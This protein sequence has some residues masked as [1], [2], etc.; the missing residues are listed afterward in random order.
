MGL[1]RVAVVAVILSSAACGGS[2]PGSVADVRPLSDG[3]LTAAHVAEAS[4]EAGLQL[5][6][7]IGLTNDGEGL[8]LS[9]S[10]IDV[11]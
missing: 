10:E 3:T 8:R 5:T 2:T 9:T 11:R 4:T 1:A 6:G 7:E